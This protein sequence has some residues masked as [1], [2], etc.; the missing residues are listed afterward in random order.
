MLTSRRDQLGLHCPM[1]TSRK[2]Q[3]GLHFPMLTSRRRVIT[4][5]CER[6][7]GRVVITVIRPAQ[8]GGLPGNLISPH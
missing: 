4:G 2:D 6:E 8:A 5:R 1:L 3:L 7:R